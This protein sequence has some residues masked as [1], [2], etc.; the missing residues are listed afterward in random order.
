MRDITLED[1]FIHPFTTRAFATGIPTVLAGSPVLSVMEA[2]NATPIT[3][4][5]SVS[6]SRGSVVG[7][8]EATIVATAANGYELG[9][10][11]GIYISTGT[12][13]SVSVV[14]E[15]VGE[16]TIGQSAAAVDLANATDGL[17]ALKAVADAIPTTVMRGTDNVVLAGPTK[18]EMD[19]AHA[20]LATI[21]MMRGLVLINSTIGAT[22][23]TTT[24]LHLAGLT[25]G[26]NEINGYTLVIFD[27]STSE[28]HI[29]LVTDW[30]LS[31]ELAT[32]ATL[33]FTPEASV[34][35]YWLISPANANQ[36]WNIVL[37]GST[38]NVANSAGKRLRQIEQAFTHASGQIAGVTDGHTFTL[39]GGSVATEDYYVGDR[40]QI[41][42]GTGAGQSRLIKAYT[43]GRVTS[44]D[45]DYTTNPDTNSLYEVIAADVHVSLSD[46]DLASG[47]VAIYTNATTIT[48]DAGAVATGDY[49]KGAI[50]LFTHG[51]GFGQ[52]QEIT[53]YT[54]GRVATL[55]PGLV[56]PIDATTVYHIMAAVSIPELV[57]EIWDE[58]QADHVAVGSFGEIATELATLLTRLS[59]A[60]AG[61]LDNLSVGAVALAS[62]VTSA[63]MG[64][65]TDWINGGRLDLLLDAV[66]AITDLLT[67]AAINA[68][69]DTAWTTQMADSVPAVGTITSREQALY[70]LV[71]EKLDFAYAS[72]TK[73]IYKADGVTVLFTLT[74]DDATNPTLGGRA[75]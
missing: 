48:L 39:D 36:I 10:T 64:A 50:I 9:K 40:L 55:S 58:A 12:V 32:V 17:T 73:T 38:F 6:V 70:M 35:K 44:L 33:P 27:N 25:Y 24:K 43:A 2:G 42:E 75:T 29:A 53:G 11:Y 3:A 28:Y 18:A 51:T 45:S 59:A 19:T 74:L 14:G 57:D 47:F 30:V 52:A 20:L 49:Y 46:A 69:A 37:T 13:D 15:L 60:R 67:L 5:V 41:V 1:T 23:N 63:R 4:G 66:K 22:G 72:T 71:R 62:E 68:E 16:F 21:D 8:N 7:Y 54:S 26:N 56:T 34:D 65:L 31:T 61:Y